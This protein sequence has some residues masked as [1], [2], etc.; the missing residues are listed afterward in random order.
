MTRGR[1][2][3]RS[4]LSDAERAERRREY[5]RAYTKRETYMEKRRIYERERRANETTKE[6]NE[7][8]AY[9]RLLASAKREGL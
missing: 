7:R 6:R 1:G 9:R 3:P 5:M 8:L 2:R 4:S